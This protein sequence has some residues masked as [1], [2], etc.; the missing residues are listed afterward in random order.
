VI[1]IYIKAAEID[2]LLPSKNPASAPAD[3]IPETIFVNPPVSLRNTS[4]FRKS[5]KSYF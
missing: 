5:L 1:E 4:K 2:K 3:L